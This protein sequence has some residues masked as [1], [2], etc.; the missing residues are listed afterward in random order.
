MVPY[1]GTFH[2][3]IFQ[4]FSQ[5]QWREKAP[6]HGRRIGQGHVSLVPLKFLSAVTHSNFTITTKRI[7]NGLSSTLKPKS[8]GTKRY[9]RRS[10][11]G[12]SIWVPRCSKVRKPE[13]H[14]DSLF[15][16]PLAAQGFWKSRIFNHLFQK[17]P[18]VGAVFFWSEISN[19]RRNPDGSPR[20]PQNSSSLATGL[21]CIL[22][23]GGTLTVPLELPSLR[24]LRSVGSQSEAA[25]DGRSSS[26]NATRSAGLAFCFFKKG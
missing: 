1:H 22:I 18:P 6:A 19:S 10:A 8:S 9:S 23:R 7:G 16:K 12:R 4:V 21:F 5:C 13:N 24:K 17:M 14:V 20:A 2:A 26:Q 25:L 3:K 11:K 15:L